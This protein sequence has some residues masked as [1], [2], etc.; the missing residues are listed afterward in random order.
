M[1]VHWCQNP[2]LINTYAEKF[3]TLTYFYPPVWYIWKCA[4]YLQ[5]IY[6]RW[7]YNLLILSNWCKMLLILMQHKRMKKF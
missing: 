3:S 4:I 5:H 1:S 6:R 7:C 2:R